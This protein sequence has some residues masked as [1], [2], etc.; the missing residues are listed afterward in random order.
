MPVL[1]FTDAE[2]DQIKKSAKLYVFFKKLMLSA[3]QMDEY[4]KSK[5][6]AIIELRNALDH[7]MRVICF[8]FHITY[9][10]SGP[11]HDDDSDDP[12]IDDPEKYLLGNISKAYG[13]VYRAGYDV[14]DWFYTI[15]K[16]RI[17]NTMGKFSNEAKVVV[18]PDY[19]TTI[20]PKVERIGEEVAKL[21]MKKDIDATINDENF[22][23]FEKYVEQIKSL[24][25]IHE[26]EIQSKVKSLVEFENKKKANLIKTI[27]I[28]AL[29]TAGLTATIT[30]IV[31][32]SIGMLFP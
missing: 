18:I 20:V 16:L 10:R 27:V 26:T 1:S 23:L 25:S 14:L 9:D 32:N 11:N 2:E 4:Q 13:H 3:E 22:A 21:R 12:K 31:S 29:I 17:K 8:K 6:Q 5:P 28:T 15:L 7:L 30:A 19:F 24:F